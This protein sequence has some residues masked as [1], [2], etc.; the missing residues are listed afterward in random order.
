[1]LVGLWQVGRATLESYLGLNTI[2]VTNVGVVFNLRGDIQNRREKKCL[3]SLQLNF[4]TKIEN[5]G[6]QT[7]EKAFLSLFWYDF[8][9]KKMISSQ[10]GS[11]ITRQ[12]PCLKCI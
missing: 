4:A 9:Y 3:P 11:P 2:E 7:D 8:F 10:I 5:Q 12:T 6:S 1:M